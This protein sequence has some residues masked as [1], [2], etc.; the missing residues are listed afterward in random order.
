MPWKLLRK[1]VL[2]TM[3]KPSWPFIS[4]AL[5]SSKTLF[6]SKGTLSVK[7]NKVSKFL[8]LLLKIRQKC[9]IYSIIFLYVYHWWTM[10][11]K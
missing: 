2:K 10:V 11:D 4:L 9:M 5:K 1:K 7:F 6:Q 8:R 3:C